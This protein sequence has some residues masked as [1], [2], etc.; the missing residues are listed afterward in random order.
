M[1][2]ASA[3]A[4]G[5]LPL[6]VSYKGAYPFRLGTT[7]FIYPDHYLPNVRMLGP[8][9]D[10]VELLMFE[11]RWPDSLP[12][13]E[14]L[15]ALADL[16]AEMDLGYNIHLPADVSLAD[17]DPEGRQRAVSVMAQ[18]IS[19]TAVLS[20]SGYAL[21]L[22]FEG[23]AMDAGGIEQWQAAA[24]EG[25]AALLDAG[26]PAELLAVENLE[27]PFEWA[28]PLVE[29][30]DL[31]VCMDMGH[32]ILFGVDPAAFF[33]KW[34]PRVRL[35]HLHGVRS[36]EG[37]LPGDGTGQDHV[38]LDQMAVE[39][40]PPVMEVLQ[41]FRGGLSIEVFAYRHLVPSLQVLAAQW[42]ACRKEDAT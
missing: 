31:A 1:G 34:E 32:L 38:G 30:F 23:Y 3:A 42:R 19:A 11:S 17:P 27:Y 7:S 5:H 22:P 28:A 36:L 13:G 26:A 35:V 4:S 21:H 20:P 39:Y 15:A 10:E 6:P 18:F 2:D 40:F 9:V 8:Y 16:G 41:R 12:D 14:T 33:R 25:I 24:A 37:L 29:E